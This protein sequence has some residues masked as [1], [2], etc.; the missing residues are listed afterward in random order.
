MYYSILITFF[1]NILLG[2]YALKYNYKS[3][4]NVIFA[5]LAFL[6][7][8]IILTNLLIIERPYPLLWSKL[9]L[10]FVI[11]TPTLY[12]IW[13]S[14]LSKI[15]L[16]V[17]E[18]LL[19]IISIFLSITLATDLF[20]KDTLFVNGKL[21]QIHGPFFGV[22][23]LYYVI[24]LLY[25]LYIIFSAYKLNN[26]PIEKRK[27]L[28]TFTGTLIPIVTS[29]SLNSIILFGQLGE[30]L[31]G[32]NQLT[33]NIYILPITNS[34]MMVFFGYAVF[35]YDFLN[36]DVSV[37]E[38][39]DTLRIRI[40]YITDIIILGLGCIIAIIFIGSGYSVDKTIIETFFITIAMIILFDYC[41]NYFLS[42]YI[43]EKIVTPIEILSRHAIEV[44]KGN[45]NRK[46][47]FEGE[48]EIAILSRQMDEMTEKLNRTSQIRENFNKA[49]QL[50]VHN[51]T[52]KLQEAY[53]KL[54]DS[55]KAKKDFI[56]AIAHE[57]YNP[58][59]IISLSNE[60]INLDKIDPDNKKMITSIQR[61][62]QRMSSL[63]KEIEDFILL[64]QESQKL[65]IERFDLRELIKTVT[66]DF[67]ILANKNKIDIFL[68]SIG[69]DFELEGDKEK[70]TKVFTNLIDNAVKF[71]NENG[72][73]KIKIEEKDHKI[74]VKI[75]DKGIGI[76]QKDMNNIFER[77]YRAK[78]DNEL[79]Q[80]IGLGLPISLDI[81]TKHDGMINVESE[82]GKGSTFTV[83]LPK[84]HV[85]L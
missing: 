32:I 8:G 29:I 71:S 33:G 2:L 63:V 80:G 21:E 76:R 41:V 5:I 37:K 39:L 43:D 44:G 7:A 47:G 67:S 81:V 19:V 31:E 49:L 50:E 4:I 51:K 52:E 24:S 55:D 66:Q 23:F 70:L 3:K 85:V 56:D 62:V 75:I 72:E 28:I 83:I 12:L 20:I 26:S 14:N 74:E 40:V 6:M 22:F 36:V 78:V 15:K 18:E 42:G 53:D 25:G 9:N 84:K 73:I 16:I 35:K 48:D 38:K 27:Y 82:Y 59:A 54:K 46:V 30:L 61:N 13:S 11:W 79:K 77:F 65:N 45:F 60:Y 57:L 68:S 58:L 1:L 34:A 69:K 10:F 64:D 17:K